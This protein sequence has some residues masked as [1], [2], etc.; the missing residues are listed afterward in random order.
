[1]GLRKQGPLLQGLKFEVGSHLGRF[2]CSDFIPVAEINTPDKKQLR[3]E[4]IYFRS[5]FQVTVH[6]IRGV[7]VT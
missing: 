6:P 1:M 2:Y 4:R 5:Q 3:G 7:E